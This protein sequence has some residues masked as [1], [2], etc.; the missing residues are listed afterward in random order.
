MQLFLRSQIK[1]YGMTS[2]GQFLNALNLI[3]KE[4]GAPE[5]VVVDLHQAQK[6][7][8]VLQFH[9]KIGLTLCILEESTQHASRAELYIGLLKE[10]IQNYMKELDSTLTLLLC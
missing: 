8:G 9:H 6:N 5:A 1:I 2:P 3:C 7:N 10:G 4:V